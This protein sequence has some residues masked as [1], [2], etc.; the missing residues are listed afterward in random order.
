MKPRIVDPIRTNQ[1]ANGSEQ[2]F[3]INGPTFDAV[4][5]E[6][7]KLLRSKAVSRCGNEDTSRQSADSRRTSRHTED[8]LKI[9]RRIHAC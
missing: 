8:E 4:G 5:A 1:N 7:G 6:E 2:R 3:R 9:A